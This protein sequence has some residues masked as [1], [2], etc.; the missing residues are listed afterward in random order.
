MRNAV[1]FLL[2]AVPVLAPAVGTIHAHA[3]PASHGSVLTGTIESP[4][5]WSENFAS[6][7]ASGDLDGSFSVAFDCA[8]GTISGGT[9]VIVVTTRAADG[10]SEVRATVRGRVLHGAFEADQEGQRVVMRDV[11][12][13]V[14][15]GTGDYA[16]IADGTGLL[17]AMSD[18]TGTPQFAGT[19]RLTF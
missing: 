10:T 6:G 18:P 8:Q 12:L 16:G 7:E 15:E 4:I 19:I 13:V 9:W 1:L 11:A 14:T 17:N 3:E 2:V 5:C